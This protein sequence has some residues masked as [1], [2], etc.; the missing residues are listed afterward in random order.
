MKKHTCQ[1][2]FT[3]G[4]IILFIGMGLASGITNNAASTDSQSKAEIMTF[5]QQ[6]SK[7]EFSDNKEFIDINIEQSFSVLTDEEKPMMPVFSKTY[8][9]PSGTK[10][11]DV[12]VIHSEIKKMLLLR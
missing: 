5:V 3:V 7:P 8:E 9:F 4:I 10:I 6:F 11:T 1:R 12:A 2:E